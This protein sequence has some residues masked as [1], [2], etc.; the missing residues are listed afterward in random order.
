MFLGN[1]GSG[2]DSFFGPSG[3]ALGSNSGT[4]FVA[5]AYNH[6]VMAYFINA[7]SGAVVAG[8]NGP[9]M[10]VTQLWYPYGLAFDASSNSLLISN[11]NSHIVVRWTVGASEW[12]LAAGELGGVCGSASTQLCQ[13][14]GVAL[15]PLGNLF[16]ADSGNHR[17][18]LFLT[19]QT[20]GMTVAGI[21]GS[22]GTSPSQLNTPFWAIVDDQWNLYISDNQNNRIQMFMSY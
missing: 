14:I 7:S 22:S 1:S 2:N 20:D 15:D 10:N 9:G 19:G 18:Q 11:F 17:I 8:G 4:I 13:P 5:D 21:T 12:I 6:R 3:L 16:V